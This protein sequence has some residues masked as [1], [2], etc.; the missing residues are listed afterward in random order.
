MD[1]LRHTIAEWRTAACQINNLL[2]RENDLRE[3]CSCQAKLGMRHEMQLTLNARLAA[4]EKMAA[5]GMKGWGSLGGGDVSPLAAVAEDQAKYGQVAAALTTIEKIKKADLRYEALDALL[6][7]WDIEITMNETV[8]SLAS[9]KMDLP[10]EGTAPLYLKSIPGHSLTRDEIRRVCAAALA[11]ARE[12]TEHRTKR[13]CT[14]ASHQS[15][16]GLPREAEKT[17]AELLV[18]VRQ[19]KE[20]AARVTTLC[21]VANFLGGQQADCH[22]RTI[23]A[24]HISAE[25]KQ[26]VLPIFEEALTAARDLKD[27]GERERAFGE[28]ADSEGNVGLLDEAAQLARGLKDPHNRASCLTLLAQFH[29]CAADGQAQQF[30]AETFA[31]VKANPDAFWRKV[32]MREVIEAVAGCHFFAD[33]MSMTHDMGGE[34]DEKI[35]VVCSAAEAEFRADQKEK[36]IAAFAEAVA[37]TAKIG[38]CQRRVNALRQIAIKMATIEKVGMKQ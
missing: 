35:S 31:A 22:F 23:E 1:Q 27:E 11:A 28:I 30:F 19:E 5:E 14:I 8:R 26:R 17:V 29:A 16:A 7:T 38:D 25:V 33:A 24:K 3:I 32:Q 34:I 37:E 20:L 9:G 21:D 4:A 2:L 10:P 13:F 18:V 12:D 15:D 36:A 6:Q